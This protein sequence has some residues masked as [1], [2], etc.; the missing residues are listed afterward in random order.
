VGF[1]IL[2]TTKMDASSADVLDRVPVVSIITEVSKVLDA[3]VVPEALRVLESASVVSPVL[4]FAVLGTAPVE[5]EILGTAAVEFAVLGTAPVGFAVLDTAPVLLEVLVAA[6][7]VLPVSLVFTVFG[8]A[9]V[10]VD[11]LVLFSELADAS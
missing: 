7:V 2:S 10:E 5:F 11:D 8:T 9:P 6:P 4:V 1:G 3:G